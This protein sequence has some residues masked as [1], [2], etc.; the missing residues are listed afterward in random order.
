[1]PK[2]S[3]AQKSTIEAIK[4]LC[5]SFLIPFLNNTMIPTTPLIHGAELYAGEGHLLRTARQNTTPTTMWTLKICE[6]LNGISVP[7]WGI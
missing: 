3:I 1:M 6:A 2:F 5:K 4:A 7:K